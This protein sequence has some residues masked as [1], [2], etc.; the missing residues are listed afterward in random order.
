MISRHKRNKKHDNYNGNIFIF[1][2]NSAMEGDNEK[3]VEND[4]GV[5]T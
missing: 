5:K 3:A 1:F 2:Y 4:K